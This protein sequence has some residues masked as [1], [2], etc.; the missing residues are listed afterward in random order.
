MYMREDWSKSNWVKVAS[1]Y[2]GLQLYVPT[3][4]CMILELLHYVTRY[5]QARIYQNGSAST[6]IFY[7]PMYNGLIFVCALNA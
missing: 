3:H 1:I 6:C 7:L 5:L 4:C 2:M